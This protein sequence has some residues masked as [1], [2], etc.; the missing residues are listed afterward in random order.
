MVVRCLDVQSR[1]NP[2]LQDVDLSIR[3]QEIFALMGPGGSGKTT[4]LR[5]LS[6]DE[7]WRKGLTIRGDI[8]VNG[9]P[10]NSSNAPIVV[11]QKLEW[12][13]K[14]VYHYL[15]AGL[16][17]RENM[18]RKEGIRF[19]LDHCR[20]FGADWVEERIADDIIDLTRPQRM[21]IALLTAA[22]SSSVLLCVDEPTSGMG[23]EEADEVLDVMDSLASER[24]ILWVSHNQ[25]RVRSIAD[26]VGLIFN[27]RLRSVQPSEEFFDKRNEHPMVRQFVTTGGCSKLVE[28]QM[29]DS[30]NGSEAESEEPAEVSAHGEKTEVGQESDGDSAPDAE[31]EHAERYPASVGEETPDAVHAV[32][33]ASSEHK[34]RSAERRRPTGEREQVTARSGSRPEHETGPWTAVEENAI[35][36][37]AFRSSPLV[38]VEEAESD[39]GGEEAGVER[40]RLPLTTAEQ[41]QLPEPVMGAFRRMDLAGLARP[42]SYIRESRGPNGFHWI[43]PGV[44]G[45]A[46]RPG[47]FK[48]LVNDLVA[49]KRVGAIHL[50]NMCEEPGVPEAAEEAGLNWYHFPVPDMTPPSVEDACEWCARIDAWVRSGEPVVV[51]CRAGIGR[52][53]T[54]IAAYL[55][56]KGVDASTA[57]RE[58]RAVEERYVQSTEQEEFL[59]EFELALE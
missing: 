4:L 14:S 24:S 15:A 43:L 1:S 19:A 13:S 17:E 44:L 23:D 54:L 8:E 34:D 59:H 16:P 22:F 18:T 11:R 10:L 6:G 57:L 48:P 12:M 38:Q 7:V 32:R 58:V 49:L 52:T 53:G 30:E 25:R 31:Y 29:A 3:T 46:P 2:I 56:F 9:E 41:E 35:L 28:E 26:R 33:E 55:V 36:N 21:C 42:T 51:H 45:G 20:R 27:G 5:A 50:I 40:G 47:V 37:A 39:R